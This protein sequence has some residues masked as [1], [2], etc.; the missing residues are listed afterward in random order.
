MGEFDALMTYRA[1]RVDALIPARFRG[2]FDGLR[3]CGIVD[4]AILERCRLWAE[5]FG[6]ETQKG[7]YMSGP[8][9]TGKSGL[10]F[11]IA[12]RLIERGVTPCAYVFDDLLAEIR[13][14]YR[15]KSG[16]SEA[17]IIEECESTPVLILDDLGAE[18]VTDHSA[19]ILYTIVN[20]R[21]NSLRPVIITSNL[22]GG[23]L[24]DRARELAAAQGEMG[25]AY[26]VLE[27]IVSRLC[28]MVEGVPL[29]GQDRRKSR[30]GGG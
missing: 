27:R 2:G 22:S 16:N 4:W 3:E 15:D 23:Q 5:D 26:R 8:V 29:V 12:R 13:S 17:E 28:E 25:E 1:S 24:L 7:L 14:T 18:R 30:K 6:P 9:G 10:A 11:A 20:R 19:R 21:Y